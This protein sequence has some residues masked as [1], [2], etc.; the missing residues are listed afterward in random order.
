MR[1]LS[2]LWSPLPPLAPLLLLSPHHAAYNPDHNRVIE[3]DGAFFVGV[4][5]VAEMEAAT[6]VAFI[7]LE[8][9]QFVAKYVAAKDIMP[10]LVAT[11]MLQPQLPRTLFKL[12][13]HAP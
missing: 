5:I 6:V 13:I 7:F 9:A 2:D 4:A 1:S 3:E 10:L 11:V 8:I 12:S